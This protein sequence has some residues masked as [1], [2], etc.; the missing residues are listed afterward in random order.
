MPAPA[1]TLVDTVGAGDVFTAGFLTAMAED[2]ALGDPAFVPG[3][4]TLA[5]WLAFAIGA[6]AR[7]CERAGCDPPRRGE[8]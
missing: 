4:E 7:T 1:I 8:L 3:D 6:A 5:R 2:G